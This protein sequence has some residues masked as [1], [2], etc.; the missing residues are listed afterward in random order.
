[1]RVGRQSLLLLCVA[2]GSKDHKFKKVRGTHH[3]VCRFTLQSHCLQV[4]II[5]H[6]APHCSLASTP[7]VLCVRPTAQP[8]TFTLIMFAGQLLVF[9]LHA[10][11]SSWSVA[12]ARLAVLVSSARSRAAATNLPT[13]SHT[14]GEGKGRL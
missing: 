1:M 13:I 7:S 4:A 5:A 3:L 12:V 8:W 14:A 2:D 10:Y 9:G 6:A 11:R